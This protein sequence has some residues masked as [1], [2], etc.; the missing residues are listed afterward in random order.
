MG[1]FYVNNFHVLQLHD[2]MEALAMFFAN[3]IMLELKTEHEVSLW[4][5]THWDS[6]DMGAKKSPYSLSVS[7][8]DVTTWLLNKEEMDAVCRDGCM[9]L[10][11]ESRK[12]K[13]L[14]KILEIKMESVY[15]LFIYCLFIYLCINL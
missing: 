15:Y 9:K 14:K 5:S 10:L 6:L 4:F 2:D 8:R 1:V 13:V 11:P 3:V 7:A 12:E